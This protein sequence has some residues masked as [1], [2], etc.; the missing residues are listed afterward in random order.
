MSLHAWE[1]EDEDKASTRP[2]PSQSAFSRSMSECDVADLDARAQAPGSEH[3]C[4]SVASSD[5]PASISNSDEP[6]VVPCNF[7]IS[8]AFPVNIGKY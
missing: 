1:C 4:S 2:R 8:L 5:G 6:Q 3:Q 7:I